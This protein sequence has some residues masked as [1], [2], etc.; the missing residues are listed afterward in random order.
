MKWHTRVKEKLR[1]IIIYFKMAK[2]YLKCKH[3]PKVGDVSKACR[4]WN[5]TC[6]L[7]INGSTRS[8]T[9][10]YLGSRYNTK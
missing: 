3:F 1:F 9:R 8:T 6:I 2:V 4:Q 10:K 7:C 5:V